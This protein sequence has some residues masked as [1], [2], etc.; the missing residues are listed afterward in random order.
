MSYGKYFSS[1]Q[2]E[3]DQKD[4]IISQ[5]KAEIF[6]LRQNERDYQDL[7]SQ[8]MNLD[9]RYNILQDE[10]LR[11]ESEYK[12][13]NDLTLKTVANLRTDIDT[14]K[15]NIAEKNIEYQ[16]L[17]HENLASKDIADHRVLDI[18]KLKN[19]LASALDVNSKLVEDKRTLDTQASLLREDKR[20]LINNTE[21]VN[22]D[23]DALA[24]R[25]S[26]LEKAIKELEYDRARFEKQNA[27]LAS[28]ID[29]LS[30]ES[31]NKSD[32]VRFTESEVGDTQ[33]Q[34]VVLEADV[35]ELERINEKNRSEA[36][37]TQKAHQKEVSKNLDLTGKISSLENNLRSKEIQID[38]H[39]REIENLKNAHNNALDHNFQLNT[40]LEHIHRQIDALQSHNKELVS[41]LENFSQEDEELRNILNRRNKVKELKMKSDSHLKQSI[42]TLATASP[43]RKLKASYRKSP[44]RL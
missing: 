34:I 42:N 29:N 27:Q 28:S 36:L 16:E 39:R 31:K 41:Q 12:T 35:K 7:S 17:K 14:L 43:G 24:F 23:V 3:S 2:V 33:K 11:S 18:S 13:R 32:Q 26:D 20:K 6:E 22:A 10:K 8:F 40:D 25:V 15:A 5:M 4:L 44:E 9:H 37:N 30:L 38:D 1:A 21:N 19:E